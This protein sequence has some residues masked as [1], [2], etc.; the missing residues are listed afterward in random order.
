MEGKIM[1]KILVV[2]DERP[3]ALQN[4]LASM[5]FEVA[6]V[7]GG[8]KAI[9][10]LDSGIKPDLLVLDMQMP[11]VAGTEVLEHMH[12]MHCNIPT[13]VLTSSAEAQD[14]FRD[15]QEL[16]LGPENIVFKPVDL[17]VLLETVKVTLHMPSVDM[18]PEEGEQYA[19]DHIDN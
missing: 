7:T 11:E 3:T 5:G 6:V 19:Q 14:Y 10:I 12:S 15:L 1:H 2:D 8:E 9:E 16:G 18:Q 13:I 4:F 17:V